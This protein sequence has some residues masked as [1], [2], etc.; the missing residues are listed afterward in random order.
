MSYLLNAVTRALK[1]EKVRAEGI[2]PAVIYGAGGETVSLSLSYVDFE[3]MYREAG[4]ASLIDISIDGKDAGKVL[5][6]EVQYDPVK[7]QMIH[8]DFYRIDMS[9]PITANVDLKFIGEAP[10]VKELGGTLVHSINEIE[11]KCL[12]KDLVSHIDI[13]VTTLKTFD[14][15]IKVKD[16][17]LPTGFA[18]VSLHEDDVL[19]VVTPALTE[20]QIKAMEEES[21]TADIS[22]IEVAGKKKEEEGEA[23]APAE[24][25]KAE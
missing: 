14:D 8:V 6:H 7:G 12:P 19:A 9:K 4:D 17:V 11:I 25:K 5:V 23:A 24:E 22:K 2:L 10:A 20:E 15:T 21:K 3:K 16:L 1:G 18:V 13:D